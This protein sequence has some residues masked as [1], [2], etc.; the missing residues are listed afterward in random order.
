MSVRGD[1][2]IPCFNSWFCRRAGGGKN[3]CN[4]VTKHCENPLDPYNVK[5]D[6]L[7]CCGRKFRY[8]VRGTYGS[9]ADIG[10]GQREDPIT[11]DPLTWEQTAE[12]MW[13][14]VMNWGSVRVPSDDA[15]FW[16][17]FRYV[18]LDTQKRA[19]ITSG[20]ILLI[21]LIVLLV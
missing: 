13:D 10:M 3:W 19:V 11:I 2:P 6:P 5:S 18:F 9:R 14:D 12:S 17:K 4:P 20:I 16:Q 15:G 21:A 8:P 1:V 7:G